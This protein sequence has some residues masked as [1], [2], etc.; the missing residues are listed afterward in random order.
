MI[1]RDIVIKN[2]FGIHARPA[3]MIVKAA[4]KYKSNITFEKD[5]KGGEVVNA[6]SIMEL[7][8]LEAYKDTKIKITANGV[9]EEKAMTTI[10]EI[11]ER[12]FDEE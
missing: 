3:T 5:G 1:K 2:R 8:L 11:I 12:G 4:S 10:I 7:L 6:K 9:D